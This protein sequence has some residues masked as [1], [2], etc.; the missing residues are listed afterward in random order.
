MLGMIRTINFDTEVHAIRF[1]RKMN[2]SYSVGVQLFEFF[3]L[4]YE[5]HYVIHALLKS[6]TGVR[7]NGGI[8]NCLISVFTVHLSL[9][10]KMA[11]VASSGRYL[12][13]SY[14]ALSVLPWHGCKF[15]SLLQ[16][17]APDWLKMKNPMHRR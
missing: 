4:L 17:R 15:C 11:T 12:W 3:S 14:E 6:L 16:H 7:H 9:P 1:N 13:W 8:V 5:P 2:F 10:A